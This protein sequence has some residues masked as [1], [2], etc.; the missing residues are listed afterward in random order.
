MS[1]KKSVLIVEDESLV[2][3]DLKEIIISL[4]Y[5]VAGIA[6]NSTAAILLARETSPDLITMD[7]NISGSVDGISTMEQ[8]RKESDVPVIYLTAFTTDPIIER[9]KKTKPSGYI[10]KPFNE[11]QIR[12]AFEIALYNNELEQKVTKRDTM[13]RALINATTDPFLLID[14]TGTI[15]AGNEATARRLGRHA[16]ELTGMNT[17]QMVKEGA[18][19][20]QFAGSVTQALEGIDVRFEELFRDHWYDVHCIPITDPQGRVSMTAVFSNDISFRKQAEDRIRKVDGRLITERNTLR[21]TQ[22]ELRSLNTQ[23]EEKVRERTAELETA[24]GALTEQ[25]RTLKI[26]NAGTRA[27]ISVQDEAGFIPHI[28]NDLV[29]SG[30]YSHVWLAGLDTNG[31]I[32]IVADSGDECPGFSS[33]LANKQLPVCTD[34]VHRMG[35]VLGI[36]M[37][38]PHCAGCPLSLLHMDRPTILTRLD[39]GEKSVALLGVTLQPGVLLTDHETVR[40]GQI[41]QEIAF[42]ILYLR[43]KERE[44]RAYDQIT[45]NLEQ[46]AIL[47]DHVR[48]P[49]QGIIGYASMGEGELFT[50]I[51]RL[52]TTINSI[53]T[54]LDEGYLESKKIR[55]FM[56]RHEHIVLHEP[57]RKA[58]TSKRTGIDIPPHSSG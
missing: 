43:T 20:G 3:E 8:I 14:T 13:I 16:E 24:N 33:M 12:S 50:K 34:P 10:I 53:V 36:S 25:N 32:G 27:L 38:A 39:I 5:T 52:S 58:D 30:G 11:R 56:E 28:C 7:I 22:E 26:S 4:G 54:K 19:S 44:Q 31:N 2:A 23:L 35:G 55:D 47:N 48:N 9:A 46:L 17:K 1:T 37:L 40:I 29:M 45:K 41:A 15:M 49:L 21:Q 42:V 6:D 18:I 57:D 51:I